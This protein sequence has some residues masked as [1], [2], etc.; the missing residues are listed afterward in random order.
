MYMLIIKGY[1][2]AYVFYLIVRLITKFNYADQQFGLIKRPNN[3]DKEMKLYLEGL[4][5][6]EKV[7][8]PKVVELANWVK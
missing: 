5:N 8:Q 2:I 1:H 7:A 4:G 6:Q 3:Y